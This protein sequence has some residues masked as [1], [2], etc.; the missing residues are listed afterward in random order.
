MIEIYIV[1]AR[2][3]GLESYGL[4]NDKRDSLGLRLPHYLGGRRPS[5]GLVQHLVR[6]C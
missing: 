2:R 6:L 3:S 5:L 4:A 1:G